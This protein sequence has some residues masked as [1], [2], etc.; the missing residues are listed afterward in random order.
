MKTRILV[1]LL[2]VFSLSGGQIFASNAP[3]K[4]TTPPKPVYPDIDA[5]LQP[6]KDMAERYQA[7]Q[8]REHQLI[9]E[10]EQG[11]RAPQ[12]AVEEYRRELSKLRAQQA[13]AASDLASASNE[14]FLSSSLLY[15]VMSFLGLPPWVVGLVLILFSL[16]GLYL[17]RKKRD[18]VFTAPFTAMRAALAQTISTSGA[19][20]VVED[21]KSRLGAILR[22]LAIATAVLMILAFLTRPAWSAQEQAQSGVVFWD[23]KKQNFDQNVHDFT[24]LK[25]LEGYAR[26]AFMLQNPVVAVLDLRE[27][28]PLWQEGLAFKRQP[29]ITFTTRTVSVNSFEYLYLLGRCFYEEGKDDSA[30]AYFAMLRDL[31]SHAFQNRNQ[32]ERYLLNLLKIAIRDNK[33]A[34]F[35][36]L[37]RLFLENARDDLQLEMA[38]FLVFDVDKKKGLDL[39]KRILLKNIRPSLLLLARIINQLPPAEAYDFCQA[40]MD[41][42]VRDKRSTELLVELLMNSWDKL[43]APDPKNAVG[44]DYVDLLKTGVSKLVD[45]QL[46]MRAL[47]LLLEHKQFDFV[48]TELAQIRQQASSLRLSVNDYLSIIQL[49]RQLGDNHTANSI[50]DSTYSQVFPRDPHALKKLLIY[51]LDNNDFERGKQILKIIFTNFR[52]AQGAQTDA[53][54]IQSLGLKLPLPWEGLPLQSFYGLLQDRV[55]NRSEARVE[56]ESSLKSSLEEAL[57][58]YDPQMNL[59]INVLYFLLK[60]YHKQDD[61]TKFHALLPLYDGAVDNYWKMNKNT[62]NNQIS[63]LENRVNELEKRRHELLPTAEEMKANLQ[64]VQDEIDKL[65]R[66]ESLTRLKTNLNLAATGLIYILLAV[67]FLGSQVFIICRA[68]YHAKQ[69]AHWRMGVFLVRFWEGNGF[70]LMM[71]IVFFPLGAP[72][73]LISQLLLR[74]LKDNLDPPAVAVQSVGIEPTEVNEDRPPAES[75]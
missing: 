25:K 75:D 2:I 24:S 28:T 23:V 52:E 74:L 32:A 31:R 10:I 33:I 9:Q 26:L 71:T 64:R 17:W 50:L 51:V 43:T 34:Q 30:F 13:Q 41:E 38:D 12:Q 62:W 61:A 39:F 8:T 21:G 53:V 35:E 11:Q 16:T 40:A 4:E 18:I 46:R 49:Y 1:V 65:R 67:T 59:N 27:A 44:K 69:A 72:M 60:I 68:G 5:H 14:G 19:E 56:L 22:I 55:H 6:F 3:V 66:E 29:A 57:K 7:L 20:P 47:A 58:K 36:E 42:L 37:E 15:L 73:V 70:A 54:L 45:L 48:R 63:R